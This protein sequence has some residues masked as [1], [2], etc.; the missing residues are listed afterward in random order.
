MWE[1]ENTDLK[2]TEYHYPPFIWDSESKKNESNLQ[3]QI[4]SEEEQ[5]NKKTHKKYNSPSSF[6]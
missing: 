1:T 4:K 3:N 5:Q 2:V 6:Y